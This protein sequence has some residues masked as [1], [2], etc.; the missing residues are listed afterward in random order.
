MILSKKIRLYPTRE[1]ES[2]MWKHIHSCRFIY[3]YML[4]IQIKRYE[5]KEKHLSHFDMTKMLTPLKKQEEYS[6]LNEV[7]TTS[8]QNICGDL[9]KAYNNLFSKRAKKPKF[10]SRKKAKL[11]F[12]IRSQKLWFDENNFAHI[13]KVGKV[14][15]KT[16][17]A[18]PIG[19]GNKYANPRIENKNGKWLLTFGIEVENQNLELTD[20]SMGIDLGIKETATVAYGDECIVLHNINKSR[21]MRLLNKK[22]KH[23]QRAI[24]RKYEANKC[25]KKYNKTK[26]IERCEQQLRKLYAKISNI[27]LNYVHQCTHKLIAMKPNRIVIEDLNVQGMMKNRHLSKAIQEQNFYEWRRQL[28]Y[29]CEFYGI[30]LVIV[31]RFY[32][33][34][35]T[36]SCCGSIKTNLKL[37]DRTYKCD[38]CGANLDRD[39]NA[40]LNLMS[41]VA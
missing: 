9:S 1:Q 15:F 13:I 6:W 21:T 39:Y 41:Y 17:Y 30:P 22:L 5:N 35:K 32:P 19:T 8:L 16:D 20:V 34:S 37:S 4:D 3:N 36:C 14:K 31:D 10:K 18:L 40:A 33:S 23:L 38:E 29:K 11:S 26:N 24:S 12:P 2:I 27:R 28:E 7:S 25:G